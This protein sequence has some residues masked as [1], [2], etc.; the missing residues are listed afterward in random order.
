MAY[1]CSFLKSIFEEEVQSAE[2]RGREIFVI[3]SLKLK[4]IGSACIIIIKNLR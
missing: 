1:R 2:I 4:K 3:V